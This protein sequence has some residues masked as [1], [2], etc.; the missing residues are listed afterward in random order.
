LGITGPRPPRPTT[1]SLL[2]TLLLLSLAG[3]N[4]GAQVAAAGT[5]APTGSRPPF[6]QR[7][8]SE[9][10]LFDV[11]L[12][13]S[14][15]VESM[16]AY[17][18][19]GGV[20]VPLSEL[21]RALELAVEVD[22]VTGTASGFFVAENRRFQLDVGARRV[23]VEGRSSTFDPSRV[24]LHQD[25]IYVDTVLF[26][27]WF[28]ADLTV[29]FSTLLVTVRPREPLPIQKR[30]EREARA[31]KE[32]SSLGY[33]GPKYPS[34]PN[35]YAL[36]D[37]PFLDQMLR[38]TVTHSHGETTK[39]F[40]YSTFLTG[41]L[42]YHEASAY[43]FGDQHGVTDAHG[44]LGRRDPAG[45]LLGPLHAT[46][47]AG[48]E[49]LFP[50]LELISLPR[51]GPGV[52]LSSYP[53]YEQTQYDRH[54]FSGDL[55]QGWQ[56]ELYQN[57]ALVGFQVSRPDGRYEFPN[58]PL[59]FGLNEFR[60]VFYGPQGQRR[61]ETARFNIAE[62]L[63]PA[64][65][66]E[67]RVVANDP[68]GSTRRGQFDVD[69]GISRHFTASLDLS[70]VELEGDSRH[71]YGRLALRG[72]SSVLFGNV[73]VV[74]DRDGGVAANV[75][76]QTRLG[77]LGVTAR[78]TGLY[79]GFQSETFRP[80]YGEIESRT[81]LRLDG[82]IP[83]GR[84]SGIPAVVDFTEDRL[85]SGRYA[86]RVTARLSG[87]FSGFS[88]SNLVDWAFSRGTPKVI[89]ESAIGD[90]LVSKFVRNYG[91]RGEL[92]YSLKPTADITS[93]ALTAE[94][95]FPSYYAQAGVLQDVAAHQTHLLASL[96]RT[97]GPFGFGVNL[98]WAKSGAF[99]ATLTFN[100]SIAR[101]PR[102]G[103]FRTQARSLAGSGAI[104]PF[105]YLDAN[106]NGRLDPGEKPLEGVGFTSSRGSSDLVTDPNGGV[107]VTGLPVYQPLDVSI[108]G[109]TLEDPLAISEKPGVQFV[110]RPGHVTRVDFPVLVSGE[111][112]GTVRV[113]RG[114]EVREASG[115]VVQI[116]SA[117]GS[118]VKEARSAYDGFYD[119]TKIVPGRYTV[120][121]SPAQAQ[122]LKL[123]A[124]EPRSIVI[125]A[126]GTILDGIDLRLEEA[127]ER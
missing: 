83:A 123:T 64:G 31:L 13:Q 43:V 108:A 69:F 65:A 38:T 62:S 53:L 24:E 6:V 121:V 66:V 58:V 106:G 11:R 26:S 28:P 74:A 84:S 23:T 94:R 119:I 115:V 51:S 39:V 103:R 105:V 5:A 116:V 47:Y 50:G 1:L 49:V 63:T 111:V 54:T 14:I 96:T 107:L 41:D 80:V 113:T 87:Y 76:L 101:D 110:P 102:T 18:V 59:L 29:D 60:L 21:C 32:M 75:G 15:L 68:R 44:T 45:N 85:A 104:A 99:A 19:K 30:Q 10:L 34:T 22:V 25:D 73:E 126:S 118:V 2:A 46:E 27:A 114:G 4:A 117:D 40:Q 90:L 57:R 81:E 67:Y 8:E 36:A 93:V 78:Y 37:V 35:D 55:P 122:R 88:V 95:I 71:D 9:L 86:D 89:D 112:T 127:G 70:S 42:L 120:R 109:P 79:S 52:L 3:E 91:L 16:P 97:E 56:V 125:E 33:S 61:E 7:P 48:G 98:D 124:G 72:Y 92:V 20:L 17:P 77:A 12:G 100:V 82:T